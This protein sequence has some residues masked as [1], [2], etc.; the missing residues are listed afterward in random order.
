MGKYIKIAIRNIWKQ[1]KRSLL[2]ASAIIS[3]LTLITLA[4]AFSNG[5]GQNI[6]RIGTTLRTG[7]INVT[8]LKK[9][10]GTVF[11]EI[12][13]IK[14]VT[15]VIKRNLP[16]IRRIETRISLMAG[17]FNPSQE[18]GSRRGIVCGVNFMKEKRLR[19][20][21]V[22][23]AGDYSALSKPGQALIFQRTAKKLNLKVGDTLSITSKIQ[24]TRFGNTTGTLDLRVAAIAQNTR[25]GQISSIYT[26][27]QD[28]RKF[29]GYSSSSAGILLIYLKDSTQISKHE[30]KLRRALAKIAPLT[31][32]QKNMMM[33]HL[34]GDGNEPGW[35]SGYRLKTTN[36][37]QILQNELLIK[38]S[39]DV[40]SW[41]LLVILVV[42]VFAGISNSLWMAIR[43]RTS[44]VGTLRAIG[45]RKNQVLT[46]FLSEGLLL[47]AVAAIIG[48]L[49]GIGLTALLNLIGIGTGNSLFT[50]FSYR[51]AL[52]FLV[53]PSEAIGLILFTSAITT[54]ASI[55][56]AFKAAK[57]RPINAINHI[58]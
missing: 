24:N 54:A 58:G 21:L 19:K 45:M 38:K 29:C 1:K 34:L 4:A 48:V 41:L 26:S 57:M 17:I 11:Q 37:E 7:H 18:L 23:M 27:I 44:E 5:A 3:G 32:M 33:N 56:P 14:N 13:S 25:G 8:G 9:I 36:Y 51:G 20:D 10:R 15:K 12:P 53:Y 35:K 31:T 42:I 43:E 52:S 16:N 39:I 46:M 6:I 28:L 47:G 40:I 22:L 49:T 55:V 30:K 2:L 50:L